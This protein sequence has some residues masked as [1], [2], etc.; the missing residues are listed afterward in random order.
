MRKIRSN[1]S[2]Q[3]TSHDVSEC[4]K[5][6]ISKQR[7]KKFQKKPECYKPFIWM[8]MNPG[9]IIEPRQS[10]CRCEQIFW[11]KNTGSGLII[12]PFWIHKS[13]TIIWWLRISRQFR[14]WIISS[15]EHIAVV[16]VDTSYWTDWEWMLSNNASITL[17]FI[18]KDKFYWTKDAII[19][20]FVCRWFSYHLQW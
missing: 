3:T 9:A 4:V 15:R 10:I 13:S 12:L 1:Y 7:E 14:N 19:V 6:A 20:F 8:S 2:K 18:T 5:F 17:W 16:I 11:S